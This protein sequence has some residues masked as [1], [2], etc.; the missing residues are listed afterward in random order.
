M[1]P[2]QLLPAPLQKVDF[3]STFFL[4]AAFFF[5]RQNLYLGTMKSF[6]LA[7]AAFASAVLVSCGGN[8]L[9]VDSTG[10]LL[11]AREQVRAAL[12]AGLPAPEVVLEDGVYA[13]REPL[14]FG[15]GDGGT[16]G[17]PV[18]YRARHKGRALITMGT[19]VPES[20]LH[21][22]TDSAFASRFKP[23]ALPEI[24]AFELKSVGIDTTFAQLEDYYYSTPS[25]PW[26][27]SGGRMA[28]LA[29]WPDR[30][31][32]TFTDVPSSTNQ[33]PSNADMPYR[34]D[35]VK[36]AFIWRDSC[37]VMAN[38]TEGIWACGYFYADWFDENIR[39]ESYDAEEGVVQLATGARFGI[40]P[41]AWALPYRRF[42]L[43][44]SPAELDSPGEWY[45]DRRGGTMYLYPEAEGCELVLTWRN[46]PIMKLSGTSGIRFEGLRF[47][48]SM[49]DAIVAEDVRDVEF[50]SCSISN[51][52]GNGVVARGGGILVSDCEIHDIGL[53][54]INMKGGDRP[55]L[56]P[57][58][59]VVE[60]C[61]IYR[62]SQMRRCYQ[63]GVSVSG[64]G[65]TVRG[66][67]IHDSP[68][69][70]IHVSGNENRILEN[71]IHDM[72][73]ETT[74]AGAI[75]SGR[76]WTFYGNTYRGN[77]IH[78]IPLIDSSFVTVKGIYLDDGVC[79]D[80][81]AGN[82]FVRVP[83]AMMIGGGRDN[84]ICDNHVED[85]LI[86]IFMDAR[87]T[88]WKQWNN[89][90]AEP[91]WHFERKAEAL[92][93][94]E[95]PWAD[96]YPRLARMMQEEPYEPL[97]NVVRNNSFVNTSDPIRF[98]PNFL[99]CL[100]KAD[101]LFRDNVCVV[102]R[103]GVIMTPDTLGVRG[104]SYENSTIFTP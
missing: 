20:V 57:S 53:S 47:E 80:T 39:V 14:E 82:R 49:S 67:H 91:S 76:D 73:Y 4:C 22:V 27:F 16:Q 64:V 68:H 60:G 96:R 3:P 40:G 9:R 26:L 63:P 18:V 54:G 56:I 28:V 84:T 92:G 46:A 23:E 95:S 30:G 90:E 35:N 99:P 32:A 88:Q 61:E 81:L 31:F 13:L 79:G 104:F 102:T 87:G 55:A 83:R 100:H 97:F 89:P 66:C 77:Y 75:Y 12:A 50:R 34:R 48:Y 36:A 5:V 94:R 98:N 72:L 86:G 93:Y 37:R 65:N 62:V 10:A 24:R 85:C 101:S 52:C 21:P 74:D 29:R 1:S 25:A 70:A 59:N 51:A 38:A 11:A 45:L 6:R 41:G 58:G 42:Y 17:S 2:V 19:P 44:N 69:M 33:L 78:D 103:P 7:A 71:D 15:P 43:H 8:I